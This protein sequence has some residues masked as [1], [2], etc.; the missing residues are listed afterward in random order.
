MVYSYQ[1]DTVGEIYNQTVASYLQ[2]LSQINQEYSK[3]ISDTAGQGD[4]HAQ[5]E[6]VKHEMLLKMKAMPEEPDIDRNHVSIVLPFHGQFLQLENAE[7]K[8]PILSPYIL[9]Q[10]YSK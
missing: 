10:V 4:A 1:A 6:R 9:Q 3:Q 7:R 5:A 2:D 8:Y